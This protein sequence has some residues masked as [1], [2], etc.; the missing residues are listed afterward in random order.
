M[1][2][3]GTGA[4]RRMPP[5]KRADH[6]LTGLAA[7]HGSD[8]S[9]TGRLGLRGA[10]GR[11]HPC[12]PDATPHRLADRVERE[13]S[14]FA[15][16]GTMGSAMA[17]NLVRAGFALT[18]WNRSRG[19]ASSLVALGAREADTAAELAEAS[20]IVVTCL[21]DT[22][23]VEAVLFGDRGVADGARPGS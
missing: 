16:L 6:A 2:G 9:W 19:R 3:E 14:G 5:S 10:R 12:V 23:D 15:G 18:V 20:D 8:T 17:A 1:I 21:S 13:R 22:P 7:G 11:Y 4:T